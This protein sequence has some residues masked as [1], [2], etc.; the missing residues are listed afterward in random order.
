MRNKLLS[1]LAAVAI[2]L[3]SFT[4]AFAIKLDGSNTYAGKEK[5]YNG[6]YHYELLKNEEE[7]GNNVAYAQAYVKTEQTFCYILF[8]VICLDVDENDEELKNNKTA[9]VIITAGGE[10]LRADLTGKDYGGYDKNKFDF[11]YVPKVR[12][13]S[14]TLE[15]RINYKN[16]I[17]GGETVTVKIIDG[18]STQSAVRSFEIKAQEELPTAAVITTK[19]T[20]KP[21]TE[22]T[23][24]E[25][26]TKP[27]TEKTTKEK[28]TK[29]TTEKTTKPTTAKTTKPTTTKPRTTK[30]TTTKA[31]TAKAKTTVQKRTNR[32]I[33]QKV[34]T[35]TVENGKN[36]EN[37]TATVRTTKA[38]VTKF[39]AKQNVTTEQ[40]TRWQGERITGTVAATGIVSYSYITEYTTSSANGG[41]SSHKKKAAAFASATLVIVACVIGVTSTKKEKTDKN[42]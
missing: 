3:V 19:P 8:S 16:G 37:E 42:D 6:G 4:P 17:K 20:T 38:Q 22:K 41:G 26:T 35:T 18:S 30:A 23:T 14:F 34:V 12:T 7:S 13:G 11:A 24:T 32:D 39:R 31:T 9:G 10:N 1:I 2:T 29:P 40:T 33:S 5:E 25:R 15:V 27:T 21:T 36:R 28:T